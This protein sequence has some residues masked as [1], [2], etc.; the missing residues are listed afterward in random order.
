MADQVL[1]SKEAYSDEWY[2]NLFKEHMS[3]DANHQFRLHWLREC[4]K[5]GVKKVWLSID[6][7]NND[8]NVT[9]SDLSEP[10]K[11]KSH[12]NSNLVSYIWAIDAESGMPV[13]YYVNN[14][15]MTDS[16][17]FQK[18]TVTLK[19]SDID[20]EGVILDRGFATHDVI[21]MLQECS[22]PFVLMLKS[23][24]Y[25]HT[26]M[27][28]RYAAD[29]RWKVT[30][31]EAVQL[32]SLSGEK[33]LVSTTPADFGKRDGT[34][35]RNVTKSKCYFSGFNYGCGSDHL[36]KK[37]HFRNMNFLNNTFV[38]AKK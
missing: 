8:C 12:T 36:S 9:H 37:D 6:A 16:K 20:V 34:Q 3:E 22:Y 26:R 17:A 23:D 38:G 35:C 21:K 33:A 2:S 28:E 13:S 1:F 31:N 15:G 4:A 7:S 29:I 32:E 19:S 10:E 24:T 5:R 18:M 25:A 27:M 30:N 11:A 14:G